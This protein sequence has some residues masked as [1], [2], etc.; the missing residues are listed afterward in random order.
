MHHV[1][2]EVSLRTV[3]SVQHIPDEVDNW[4][5]R[6][7]ITVRPLPYARLLSVACVRSARAFNGREE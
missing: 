3:L 6:R 2:L 5:V 7:T 1:V 4:T